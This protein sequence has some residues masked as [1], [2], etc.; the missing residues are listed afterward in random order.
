M[1]PFRR[2]PGSSVDFTSLEMAETVWELLD[3]SGSTGIGVTANRRGLGRDTSKTGVAAR[4][5][6][7]GRPAVI[8]DIS[9]SYVGV[10]TLI[11]AVLTSDVG[12]ALLVSAV[13]V[14][15]LTSGVGVDLLI[16]GVGTVVSAFD[17]IPVVT[18]DALAFL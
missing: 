8:L 18:S 1:S 7:R 13:G 12:V 17:S 9:N 10:L 11:A 16:S 6:V 14:V 4:A 3:L 15:P 2:A 5:G